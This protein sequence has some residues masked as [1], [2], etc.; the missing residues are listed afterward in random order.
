MANST[1]SIGSHTQTSKFASED[2][3]VKNAVTLNDGDFVSLEN[4][5]A[6]LLVAGAKVYGTVR[7]GES[8]NLVSRTY[9]APTT[10]GDGTKKV[11]VELV[12]GQRYNLPVSAALASDAAGKYYSIT[13]ATNAQVIDNTSKSATVGQFL[14]LRRVANASGTYD[15]GI[16]IVAAPQTGTTPA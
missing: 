8:S 12:N 6:I 14:C 7:G 4:E 10:V 3:I 5:L 9:R 15:R 1:Q 2:R 16:F 11:N 13:G